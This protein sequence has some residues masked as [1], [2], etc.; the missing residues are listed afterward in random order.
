MLCI[1]HRGAMGHA[2]ENTLL[3]VKTA[4]EMDVDWI[5]IDVFFVE[6]ELVVIHDH[7]LERTTNGAGDVMTHSLAELRA[8]DAGA[9]QQIPLLGEVFDLANRR[10]GI[11]I[12]LKGPETAV[13]VVHFIEKQ[14]AAGWHYDEILVSSFDHHMLQTVK[15]SNPDI[16]IGVLLFQIPE[17]LA[18]A[19]QEM[20][21]FSV[22]PWLMTVTKPFVQDAHDRGL[23]VF[24][25][26]VNEPADIE[27]MRQ[28]GVDGIFTN[29]PDRVK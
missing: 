3:S 12:E 21:A 1:G 15:A 20:E 18:Q 6:G 4:L 9:G 14:I 27:R 24:V 2:P 5:E 7:L 25:Y 29:Y 22:N 23:Q 16:K 11:N 17:T 13:P 19:A 8:L 28:W 10:A 26:T